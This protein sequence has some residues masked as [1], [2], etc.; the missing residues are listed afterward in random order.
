MLICA[1]ISKFM[2]CC[3]ENRVQRFHWCIHWISFL[4]KHYQLWHWSARLAALCSWHNTYWKCDPLKTDVQLIKN[5]KASNRQTRPDRKS[6]VFSQA[7]E[8]VLKVVSFESNSSRVTEG[9]DLQE[10]ESCS[11]RCCSCGGSTSKSHV[12][13]KCDAVWCLTAC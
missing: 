10:P 11:L 12:W 7:S 2:I 13:F 4:C 9:F 5:Y 8:K 6:C 1:L 3:W